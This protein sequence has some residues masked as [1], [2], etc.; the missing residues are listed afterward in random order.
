[1][2]RTTWCLSPAPPSWSEDPVVGVEFRLGDQIPQH[3]LLQKVT[4]IRHCHRSSRKEM[5]P[6]GPHEWSQG[7]IDKQGQGS[8][9]EGKGSFQNQE[10][11]VDGRPT[12]P[13]LAQPR[14]CLVNSPRPPVSQIPRQPPRFPSQASVAALKEIQCFWRASPTSQPGLCGPRPTSSRRIPE[15]RKRKCLP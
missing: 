5:E 6:D 2:K 12:V 1:M 9:S 4:S 13:A 14:T 8:H 10:R 11:P 15:F 7:T 3:I